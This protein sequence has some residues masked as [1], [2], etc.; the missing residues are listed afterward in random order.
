MMKFTLFAVMLFAATVFS[1]EEDKHDDYYCPK[2]VHC[3]NL[4]DVYCNNIPTPAANV[5]CNNILTP[6]TNVTCNN[7]PTPATSVTCN[8]IPAVPDVCTLN[9]VDQGLASSLLSLA[10]PNPY[11]CVGITYTGDTPITSINMALCYVAYGPV[12]TGGPQA[13]GLAYLLNNL[14]SAL[15]NVGAQCPT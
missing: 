10:T 2:E 15:G 4:G 1:Y 12:G 13:M 5:T 3:D 11:T 7:I 6:A 8:N 9:C 14:F